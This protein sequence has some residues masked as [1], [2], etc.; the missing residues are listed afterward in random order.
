MSHYWQIVATRYGDDITYKPALP[1]TVYGRDPAKDAGKG[2]FIAAVF[3]GGA[4]AAAASHDS[5]NAMHRPMHDS[6]DGTNGTNGL[7]AKAPAADGAPVGDAVPPPPPLAGF[8]MEAPAD[9]LKKA[10]IKAWT[11]LVGDW[12]KH[13][14][15]GMKC[16]HVSLAERPLGDSAWA[17]EV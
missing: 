14:R 12:V 4:K 3:G 8:V 9:L 1:V 6:A 13:Y 7:A 10:G 11:P 17:T 15:Y 5:N 16:A 2:S